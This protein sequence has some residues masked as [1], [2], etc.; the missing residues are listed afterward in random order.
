MQDTFQIQSIN[1]SITSISQSHMDAP[2]PKGRGREKKRLWN[3][4]SSWTRRSDNL[5]PRYASTDLGRESQSRKINELYLGSPNGPV[6]PIFHDPSQPLTPPATPGVRPP[7]GSSTWISFRPHD[8]CPSSRAMP[9]VWHA[10]KPP[11]LPHSSSPNTLDSV[12]RQSSSSP[13]HPVDIQISH[14]SLCG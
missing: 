9:N 1:R 3:K 2:D 13:P 10:Q 12:W 5:S 14:N 8:A 7:T 4:Q 11:S 6:S